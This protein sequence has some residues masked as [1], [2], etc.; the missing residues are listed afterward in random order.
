MRACTEQQDCFCLAKCFPV[1]VHVAGVASQRPELW[2]KKGELMWLTHS[3]SCSLT[4]AL[5]FDTRIHLLFASV[6]EMDS[7][8]F[9]LPILSSSTV[10]CISVNFRSSRDVETGCL[11]FVSCRALALHALPLPSA[12]PSLPPFA[13]CPLSCPSFP[14]YLYTPFLFRPFFSLSLSFIAS[15]SFLLRRSNLLL[16]YLVKAVLLSET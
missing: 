5:Q 10:R 8:L 12:L 9:F 2:S 4:L 11:L 7:V 13:Y 3:P 1:R 16:S 15:F 14:A 6:C